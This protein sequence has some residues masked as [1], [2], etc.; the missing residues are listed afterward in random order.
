[1]HVKFPTTIFATLLG[2]L[3]SLAGDTVSFKKYITPFLEANCTDCHD[4]ETQKGKVELHNIGGDFSNGDTVVMWERVL[5]QLEIGTMP[6]E[7]KPQP[8]AAERQKIVNWIK[9]GLKTAGKGFEIESRM[10]LPEFGNR[11][12]HELLFDGSISTPPFTPS[13]LWKMSPHIYGGKKYQPHVTGGIEAQPV[14]Y[15]SKSSGLRDFADQEIM[16]EAG[17]LALQLALS[18]IIANQIHDRELAPMSYG[19]NKGKPIHIP[20]KESFKAISEAQ[21]KPPR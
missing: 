7:K 20:G 6:P 17:F 14:S 13:R 12:N 4:G 18:D 10:L 1:M 2:Q 3:G 11:V 21:G 5:E 16:D 8:T 15:K 9:E 19:P